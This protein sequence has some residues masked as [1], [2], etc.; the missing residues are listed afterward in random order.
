MQDTYEGFKRRI[1]SWWEEKISGP[2]KEAGADF[3]YRVGKTWQRFTDR[4]FGTTGRG[5]GLSAEAVRSMVRSA[6]TGNR[7]YMTRTMGDSGMLQRELGGDLSTRGLG[8]GSAQQMMRMG[9]RPTGIGRNVGGI[10]SQLATPYS[11]RFSRA[12]IREMQALGRAAQGVT[13][14]EEAAAIGYGGADE[15]RQAMGSAGA[16]QIQ[17]F[18][19][20]GEVLALRGR[21]GGILG[22]YGSM[23]RDEQEQYSRNI[24]TRI[25]AGRAGEKARQ[26][27]EG[28][29]DR[30]ALGR[31]QAMQG[32]ARGGFTGMRGLGSGLALREGQELRAAVEERQVETVENLAASM[33]GGARDS[34]WD[35][36]GQAAAAY[37]GLVGVAVT[38][39]SIEEIK[40]DPRGE[41]AMRAFAR[42]R[43][44]R[45]RG[46]NEK[47]EEELKKARS[48]MGEI[49]NDP[50]TSKAA[51]SAAIKMADGSD[52]NA[53]AIADN[54]GAVGASLM[55]ADQV[56]FNEKV[57]R[58]RKRLRAG[59]GD[60]GMRLLEKQAGGPDSKLTQAFQG[61]MSATGKT[62]LD[63]MEGLARA[64]AADPDK[65]AA[66]LATLKREGQGATDIGVVLEQAIQVNAQAQKM[67]LKEDIEAGGA[68]TDRARRGIRK[69]LHDLGVSGK[70]KKAD[71]DKLIRGEDV[72]SVRENLKA[73]GFDEEDIKKQLGIM[74][75]G[76]T[77]AEMREAGVRGA[78]ARGITTMSEKVAKRAGLDP[79][80]LE[81]KINKKDS[82]QLQELK[83]HTVWFGKMNANLD[84]IAQQKKK[85]PTKDKKSA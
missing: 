58:R 16:R 13:G 11:L 46:N 4:L 80:E 7:D 81:G 83:V 32:G 23:D 25:R 17:D 36:R 73:Q 27:F 77:K 78:A 21:S 34:W 22:T 35:P 61:A 8:M 31:L 20:S 50:D 66:M 82:A 24:L 48:I 71:I 38:E 29:S 53:A 76:M 64:A 59:M 45:R 33:R 65:A 44:A 28:L 3:S 9:F 26:M 56:A 75:G 63:R 40:K 6:I 5:V 39:Q 84:M 62:Y 18:M 43:E 12:N 69:R 52:A 68:I 57:V 30:Q 79:S 67:G 85:E 74:R 41:Q 37:G 49:A 47:A 10:L 15:M 55:I 19:R 60:R 70:L 1:G 42:A 2:L 72:E 54:A 51:R 14:D